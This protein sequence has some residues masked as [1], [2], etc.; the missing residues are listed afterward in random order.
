MTA[1]Q[2]AKFGGLLLALALIAMNL[3][4]ALTSVAPLMERI[5][6]DLELSRATAGLV[7]TIPVILMGLMAP[8]AP[9]LAR[10]WTQERVLAGTM[11]LLAASLLL[12][13]FSEQGV[14]W[15]LCSAFGAGVSIAIAGPL[16]SG[17]IKQH[18]SRY[19]GAV[20]AVYSVG[21]TLGA[22]IAV[23]ATLPLATVLGDRW[24][25]ALASWALLAILA[26][27]MWC[28]LVPLPAQRPDNKDQTER[29]PFRSGQAW[30]LTLMFACQSGVF[31]ALSTWLVAHYEQVGFPVLQASGYASLFMLFGIVGAFLLPLAA[32]KVKDRRWLIIAVNVTSTVMILLIAW[33]PSDLPWLVSSVVGATTAGTFALVLALPVLE[34]NNPRQAAS[35]TAMMLSAGY[36]LA[37]MVPSLIGI[38]RDLT[39]S[40]EL[41]FTL[42]AGL[43]VMIV[44]LSMML[45]SAPP[46]DGRVTCSEDSK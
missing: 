42:L 1:P 45:R 23:A 10:R 31:Y 39:A 13:G 22:A 36:L 40:Y 9:T 4:P 35:L 34:T 17:F 19:M 37:G 41:P 7:T 20:I 3:R 27:V 16:M 2:T 5:V 12:R 30:L 43:G 15:L 44:I 8:L 46:V 11:A 6:A 29:L 24:D 38:G 18:F 32:T 14:V 21:I 25:L 33:F 28:L 26:L